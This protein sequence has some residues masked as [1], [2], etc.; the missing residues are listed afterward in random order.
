MCVLCGN[1]DA[2]HDLLLLRVALL[3]SGS[4]FILL[5]RHWLRAAARRLARRPAPPAEVTD[6]SAHP[7]SRTAD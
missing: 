1:P 4:G 3:T 5:P 7:E 2:S 6:T